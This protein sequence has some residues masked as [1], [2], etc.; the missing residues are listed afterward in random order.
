VLT[1]SSPLTGCRIA[2]R[3][4]PKR[5]KLSQ[6][7][8]VRQKNQTMTRAKL[9]HSSAST[10]LSS[11]QRRVR[12]RRSQRPSQANAS[13]GLVVAPQGQLI[14]AVSRAVRDS[15]RVLVCR[16]VR[17]K[18]TFVHQRMWPALVRLAP[19][20][21]KPSLARISEVHTSSGRHVVR[22]LAF[23]GGSGQRPFRGV[24]AQRGDCTAKPGP[25]GPVGAAHRYARCPW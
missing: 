17:G 19:R 21:P 10:A 12:F 3:D 25:V 16:A 8:P 23:R 9:W 7:V 6:G 2:E 4:S 15:E 20:L 13:A 24:P 22:T 1:S 14:F 11:N 5:R 18:V